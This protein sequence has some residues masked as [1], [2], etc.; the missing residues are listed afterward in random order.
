MAIIDMSNRDFSWNVIW[1]GDIHH[2]YFFQRLSTT[3]RYWDLVVDKKVEWIL[4]SVK[5]VLRFLL[6]IDSNSKK[7]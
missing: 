1:S 3:M 4:S 7:W 5:D 2:D 6:I